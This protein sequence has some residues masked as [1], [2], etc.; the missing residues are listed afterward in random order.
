M[1]RLI[2]LIMYAYNSREQM[3]RN[4]VTKLIMMVIHIVNKWTVIHTGIVV[5]DH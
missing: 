3:V 2:S 5:I 1:P 4:S